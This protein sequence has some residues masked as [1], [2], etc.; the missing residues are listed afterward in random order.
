[1]ISSALFRSRSPVG[2]SHR[3][4]VGVRHD[5]ARDG[6]PLLLASGELARVVAHAVGE[7][8]HRQGRLH[9]RAPLLARERG[10]EERQLDVA[11]RGEDRDQVVHLED[12][13]DVARAPAVSWRR[14]MGVISS[15]AT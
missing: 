10:E 12:E 9:V 1:M 2:S 13:P 4:K 8:H 14:E 15:P 11:V 3:R 5:G 6:H 7:P